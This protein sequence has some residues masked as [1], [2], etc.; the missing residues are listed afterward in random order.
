MEGKQDWKVVNTSHG[1]L[2]HWGWG[3]V[4][5]YVPTCREKIIGQGRGGISGGHEKGGRECCSISG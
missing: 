2:P 4:H 3:Q 5:N 1:I